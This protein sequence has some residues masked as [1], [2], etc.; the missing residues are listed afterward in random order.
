MQK[1][2]NIFKSDAKIR[3]EIYHRLNT[4]IDDDLKTKDVVIVQDEMDILYNAIQYFKTRDIGWIYPSKSYMVAICYSRWLAE[5]FGGNHMDYLNDDDLL[6]GNDPYFVSYSQ[7]P[8]MYD[9]LLSIV[10][11]NF[12][13]SMGLVPDVKKYFIAE[14]MI[15]DQ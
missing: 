15:D 7:D 11:W 3:Q 8:K 4:E 5:H 10:G 6:H 2:E 13:E 12:D 14:F 9:S 1:S